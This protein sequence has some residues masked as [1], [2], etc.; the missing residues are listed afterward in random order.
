MVLVVA[1]RHIGLVGTSS[2]FSSSALMGRKEERRDDEESGKRGK[3]A[4]V[5]TASVPP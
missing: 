1:G 2:S 3:V 5:V 4:F